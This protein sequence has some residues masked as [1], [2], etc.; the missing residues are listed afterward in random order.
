MNRVIHPDAARVVAPG[1]DV[2]RQLPPVMA[3][4]VAPARPRAPTNAAGRC[5]TMTISRHWTGTNDCDGLANSGLGLRR[6]SIT[7]ILI[8]ECRRRGSFGMVRCPLTGYA[9]QRA[10][11]FHAT[12]YVL[13]IDI[14][15]YL[16]RNTIFARVICHINQRGRSGKCGLVRNVGTDEMV[17]R[18]V[19]PPRAQF[20][21]LC[22]IH[23]GRVRDFD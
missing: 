17:A 21:A 15:T 20:E 2:S 6:L 8:E 7:D 10:V 11:L 16:V 5:R 22:N 12:R 19:D 23:T 1:N 18:I 4:P 3:R 9:E 13:R 14:V